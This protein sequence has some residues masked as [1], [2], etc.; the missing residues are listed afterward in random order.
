M[1]SLLGEF[2]ALIYGGARGNAIHVEN[3]ER[4]QPQGNAD[5]G[6]KLGI[7]T[8]KQ[9]LKLMVELDLPAE[10]AEDQ[11]CRKITV[12]SRKR[13][14]GFASQKVVRVGVAALDS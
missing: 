5:F 4:A 13:V 11:G 12:C 10:Y 2:N 8:H 1:A 7:G 3:L 14:D 9:G 6:I